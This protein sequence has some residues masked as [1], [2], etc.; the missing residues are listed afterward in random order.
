MNG[1]P[2][3]FSL[4]QPERPATDAEITEGLVEEHE[5]SSVHLQ[6]GPDGSAR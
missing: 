1:E 3:L 4:G 6:A 5:P 2:T